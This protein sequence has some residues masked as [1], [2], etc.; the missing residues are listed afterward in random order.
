M[1]WALN[2]CAVEAVQLILH[3]HKITIEMTNDEINERFPARV[4][5]RE[6]TIAEI[7]AGKSAAFGRQ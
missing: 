1:Y 4:Q 2:C 6:C 5:G 7:Y 3:R